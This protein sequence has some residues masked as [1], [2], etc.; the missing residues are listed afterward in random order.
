MWRSLALLCAL[1]FTAFGQ[2]TRG[3]I[4]GRVTDASG[5]NVS[6]AE[7]HV[8]NV[9][10]GV[11]VTAKTNDSGNYN[12]PYLTPGMYVVTAELAGFKKFVRDNVQVR[13]NDSVEVN[14]NLTVGDVAESVEVTAETPLLSTAEASLGQVV[15]ERRVME[16][17]IFSGNAM[18]FTLLAPGTVN[19]T[20][21]RLRKAPFNNAPSQFSTDGSGLFNNEFNIDGITNT[22]SDS[23]NV[24]VAFSPPQASIQEFKVQTSSF[25][26][27]S[28]HTM[29]SVV[30]INS[31]GGSSGFH[32]SAWWWLRHS[33]LDAP[34]IFQNRSAQPG[35]RKI[36]VYQDNRYGLSGGAPV[37]IP[38]IYN[39]KN[40]T[41]WQFTWEANK[42]GDPNVGTNTSTVPR[43]AW[44]NGDFS[45]LL[46]LGP[47]YQLYD[48]STIKAE[49]N[50]TFSRLPFVGNIIPANRLDPVGKALL[51]LYPLPNQPGN[52]DGGNNYFLTGKALEDYW[53]TIGRVDHVINE[54]NRMFVRVHR[55]FWQE[56]KNRSF[57][58][59]V[60]GIILN[61][62][63]RAIAFD[64]VH[65]FTPTF[66]LNFR[67]G[68]TQQE[69][70]EHRVSSGFDLTT[71]G[72]SPNL[73]KLIAGTPALPNIQ[74]GNLTQISQ[75]ESGDGVASSLV[76]TFVGNFTWMR[77]NHSLRFGPEFRLYRVFSDR[78]SADNAP[79]LNFN[80]LWG[81]GPNNTSAAPPVGGELVSVLLGIP[82]GNMT[83]SGSFAIQDKYFGS[84]LQ[85]DWKVSKKLTVNLGLRIEHESPV[86]ERFNRSATGFLAGTPNP[87]AAA[88]MA[89][90][91]KSAQVPEVPLAAFKVNGG[92]TFAG[93]QNR[94]LWSGMG[95]TWLPRIGLAYQITDKTVLRAGYGIFYGSIGSFK[96]GA[97]LTGFSQSTPIEATNDNGLTF[98][99]TL[100]NPLPG[101][102]LAP[103]GAAGGMSTGLNQNITYFA[104][105]RK[106]PYAQRWSLGLQQQF[107]G[108]FVAE[109]SYVGNRGTRLGV[110]RNINSTPLQYLS[111]APLRDA[112]TIT[113]LGAA[114][115]NPFFGLDPQYTSSTISREQMLRPYPE[116]GTV[117]YND[118]VGYSWYH[119]L[120]SRLEK[121]MSHGVTL[122]VS[123]TYSK[124]M[125]ATTFLNGA[126][127]MPYESLG[128]I[129]RPHRIVSSGIWELPFGKGRK[130]GANMPK[131]LEFFVGGWQLSG[132]QQRQSGQPIG[133]GQ[134]I[135][136][137]DS[138][139]I[140][141]PSDQRNADRWFNTDVFSKNSAVQVA[142]NVRTFPLR[143]SNIRLDS[144]RRWDF[145]LNK[146]FSISEKA[147]MRFRADA[148]NALNEPVLRGP[149]TT[150]TSGAFGTITAQEPPRSFQ[151][152]LQLMF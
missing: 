104:T 67:Y 56:D 50:G 61:R 52:P 76:H 28:G 2:D 7:V 19:G 51:N 70:P 92:L 15:D 97:L 123:Y 37:I 3:A 30:N 66:L 131:P 150:A 33:D 99:A 144:Q 13:V 151:F 135:I 80:N 117:T 115:P 140:T 6:G 143:F 26:A 40:R 91:A 81:K 126:D 89:N 93:D 116:F 87:I 134:M 9:A 110:N 96:T 68:V 45:D 46:K 25:D 119:S 5:A 53:S 113:Y 83:R 149:N 108:G 11:S 63:N 60:N 88:A 58:N 127:P 48:P 75:S 82:G 22:F 24:R 139:K 148:F 18:E 34:S 102:L 132:V 112:A 1:S 39:G 10:T 94:N 122:Q 72:F 105:D 57:G 42:F 137:G 109:A 114:F 84:Y 16:L 32:G 86:T 145:S 64:D 27:S 90:Y 74:I 136:V 133:W 23:V 125:E 128:D 118:P 107:K 129:D 78:H 62:I 79:V 147:R 8:S 101:G 41:F 111:T 38:K 152:A 100:A 141:L 124:A 17:P 77:G 59:D 65:V 95:V 14:M 36:A 43:A 142:S 47:N 54:K 29:G 35:Q 146:T 85:D 98:K 138:T 71:L 44:R 73:T 49:A 21:M 103:L 4:L 121:R 31:K 69:F 130:F 106:Q 20:D 55:D 120:Q 12:V